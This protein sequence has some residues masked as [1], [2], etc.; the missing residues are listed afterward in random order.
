MN[1]NAN[2]ATEQP[3]LLEVGPPE[4][5]AFA[6]LVAVDGR[7]VRLARENGAVLISIDARQPVILD[8]FQS[9][10]F[11]AAVAALDGAA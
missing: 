7:R 11:V 9:I 10:A 1:E 3:A 6:T 2:P 5:Q 4:P 8:R